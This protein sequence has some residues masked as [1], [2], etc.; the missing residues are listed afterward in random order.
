MIGT[1]VSTYQSARICPACG[2]TLSLAMERGTMAYT[3]WYRCNSPESCQ[4]E[5][6]RHRG[7][8]PSLEDFGDDVRAEFAEDYGGLPTL[9]EDYRVNEVA[10]S[11]VHDE[12]QF[13]SA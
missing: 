8:E 11:S 6:E 7:Y 10:F 1:G 3:Y 13:Q 12:A 2:G 9:D 5:T 4:F